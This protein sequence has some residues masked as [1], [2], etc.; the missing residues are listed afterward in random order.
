MKVLIVGSGGREH[1]LAWKIAQSDLVDQVIVTPGNP[2]IVLEPKCK[3]VPIS[4]DD[5]PALLELAKKEKVDLTVVGPEAP[6]VDGISDIF[7]NAGLKIFGPSGKAAMLEGSKVF[8]KDLMNKYDIP[9]ADFRVF[10]D[11]DS[12]LNHLQT[13][14]GPIVLKA[15]GLAAGKGVLVCQNQTE[16]HQALNLIIK[17]R[18]FGEAG[19][20]VVIEEC[21]EGEEASFIAFTDGTTVL[22]LAGSQDH[23]A[24]FDGD[25]GPNTGG[26]GAYS[27]AP[28]VTPEIH[29]FIMN[30]IMIPTVR[31]MELEGCHYTG[32]L[33]AGV[34]IKNGVAKTLE[35]NVRLGD[36]ETQPLLYRMKSDIMPALIAVV[37]NRLRDVALEWLDEDAVC[38]VLASKGYPG[39]YEKGKTIHGLQDAAQMEDVKVFHAGTAQKDGEIVTAGGRVL[40]VT[41]KAAGI[42]NAISKAYAAV[43]RISWEGAQYRSD[44]GKKALK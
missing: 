13:I 9:T 31:A 2:G 26:M 30:R 33:Y 10:D 15:D 29:D 11:Y 17:D 40:G 19:A 14:S 38:V 20:K 25:K 23:K 7:V 24:I 36:P 35:F 4:S 27:P 34:M 21:L 37:E 8:S 6:L 32:F 18:A 22:P 28:V 44:I 41:A 43:S 1:T 16:A 3:N 5:I 42:E 39:S 12:A